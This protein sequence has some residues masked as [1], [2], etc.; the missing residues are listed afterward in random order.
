MGCQQR[1]SFSPPVVFAYKAYSL[2]EKEELSFL[3]DSEAWA[4]SIEPNFR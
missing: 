4:P 1:I 2:F 3:W